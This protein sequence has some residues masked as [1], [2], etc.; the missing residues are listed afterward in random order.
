MEDQAQESPVLK[1]IQQLV[2][3]EHHLFEKGSLEATEDRRLAAIQVELDQCWDLLRQRRALSETGR[4]VS[5]AQLR[6]SEVVEK[7]IG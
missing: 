3:E 1:H 5:E 6:P 7:Y 4:D 2:A